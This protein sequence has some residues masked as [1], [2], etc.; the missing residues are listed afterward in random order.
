MTNIPKPIKLQQNKA[1][2]AFHYIPIPPNVPKLHKN[3]I[4]VNPIYL[5]NHQLF[6][7]G[8][9]QITLFKNYFIQNY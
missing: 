6:G 7:L 5:I 9:F 3:E 1:D 4:N 8:I 2:D